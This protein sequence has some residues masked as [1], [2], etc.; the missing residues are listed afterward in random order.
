MSA[1]TVLK[2]AALTLDGRVA[3]LTF[4]R[5]DV[6][7]LTSTELV[8]DICAGFQAICHKTEDHAE[9]LTAFFEKRPGKFKGC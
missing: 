3:M 9:A 6:H 7:A 4:E 2:D 1:L 5:D 8:S